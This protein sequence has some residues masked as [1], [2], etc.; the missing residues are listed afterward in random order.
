MDDSAANHYRKQSEK[1]NLDTVCPFTVE[2]YLDTDLELSVGKVSVRMQEREDAL[3]LKDILA[4][5]LAGICTVTMSDQ[6]LVD[7]IHPG[8]DKGTLPKYLID[9]YGYRKDEIA[10]IGDGINDVDMFSHVGLCFAMESGEQILKDKADY[11]V[12]DVAEC[13]DTILKLNGE[14]R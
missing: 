14:E 5:E 13:V 7:I 3:R 2:T 4:K 1:F 10:C 12:K 11:I 8:A 6:K 9:H